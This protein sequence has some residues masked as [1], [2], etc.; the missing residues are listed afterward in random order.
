[1]KGDA[2]SRDLS[3]QV[4]MEADLSHCQLTLV[5]EEI[6][7]LGVARFPVTTLGD[8]GVHEAFDLAHVL[9]LVDV[10]SIGSP[11]V[12][13]TDSVPVHPPSQAGVAR[14]PEQFQDL[15]AVDVSVTVLSQRTREPADPCRASDGVQAEGPDGGAVVAV[16]GEAHCGPVD[17]ASVRGLGSGGKVSQELLHLLCIDGRIV[18]CHTVTSGAQVATDLALH[19][20]ALELLPGSFPVG[21]ELNT[22]EGRVVQKLIVADPEGG[23]PGL[24]VCVAVH[25]CL[26]LMWLV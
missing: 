17:V 10:A 20:A 11:D 8:R 24:V 6:H 4:T 21:T 16:D 12:L 22:G 15:H 13:G 9:R 23:V 5:V 26:W 25:G 1:M 19:H 7:D 14:E 3:D 18:P 2:L